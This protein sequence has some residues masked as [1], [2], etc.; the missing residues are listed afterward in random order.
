LWRYAAVGFCG[1]ASFAG[2][3]ATFSLFTKDRFRL[4]ERGTA[5]L[6]ACAGIFLVIVQTKVI[7]PIGARLGAQKSMIAGLGCAAL[8]LIGV[9]LSGVNERGSWWLALPS[10]AVLTFGQGLVFPNVTAL[11]AERAPTERR[12][13]ALGFQQSANALARVVGPALAGVLYEHV[14]I[15]APYL[16][17]AALSLVAVALVAPGGRGPSP[18]H[19]VVPAVHG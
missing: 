16:A 5:I 13:Q 18:H 6:L 15:P 8:G 3:E 4:D 12:G 1:I 11:V 17:G 9:G 14:S 10:M 19:D 7:R 2:F